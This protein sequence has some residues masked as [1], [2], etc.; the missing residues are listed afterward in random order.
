MIQILHSL[1]EPKL[2]GI[3]VCSLS[4]GMQDLD[5]RP[6]EQLGIFP[7]GSSNISVLAAQ[8]FRSFKGSEV[9]MWE[10]PKIRGTLLGVHNNRDPTRWVYY[11]RVPYCP[12]YLSGETYRKHNGS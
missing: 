12:K 8:P 7:T 6:D 1:K 2:W 4:W 5:H 3:M 9:P 10:F 11:S